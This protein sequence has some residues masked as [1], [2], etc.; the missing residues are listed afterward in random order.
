MTKEEAHYGLHK[1]CFKKWFGLD[2]LE[3]FSDIAIRSQSQ[4]ALHRQ[5][6]NSSFFHGKFRK[7]SSNLSGISHILKVQQV[8]YPELP[9]TEFLCNQIYEHL[10]V[11]IPSYYL[12]R[13]PKKQICFVTKNFMSGVM[14]AN[15]DH[16]Y[17]FIE[18]EMRY[19]CETLIN[20]IG[21]KTGRRTEQENFAYL[22]LVDSLIGNH[23]RHGRNLGFIRSTK[24]IYL[25][26]FYDNPSALGIENSSLLEADLQ[27]KGSIF[28][29]NSEEPTTKDYVQEWRRLGYQEVIDRLQKACLMEP[30]EEMIKVSYISEKRQKAL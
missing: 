21:E 8:G 15:L 30:I 23:D 4:A 2:R 7:Y 25:A 6:V 26:P 13:F 29:K 20:I 19:D 14:R 18:A 17:H 3:Q 5:A 11:E 24:G 27:P 16:F 1:A 22:T 28:T 10:K 12:I 9:A